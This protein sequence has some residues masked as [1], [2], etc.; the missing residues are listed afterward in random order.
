[1][2][3]KIPDNFCPYC[4]KEM[5]SMGINISFQTYY[6][7]YCPNNHFKIMRETGKTNDWVLCRVYLNAD[8]HLTSNTMVIDKRVDLKIRYYT[9]SREEIILPAFDF[10]F[11]S[12]D[13]LKEKMKKYLTF[14]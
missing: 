13:A 14:L 12:L 8:S 11:Y 10:T 3:P 2:I 5:I 1:M 4:K 7:L 9:D 6:H